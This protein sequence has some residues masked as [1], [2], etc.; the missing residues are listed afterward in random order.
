MQ[1]HLRYAGTHRQ[2][3]LERLILDKLH[4]QRVRRFAEE[5][6]CPTGGEHPGGIVRVVL[7]GAVDKLRQ[8]NALRDSELRQRVG[9]SFGED[10]VGRAG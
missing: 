4:E 1:P 2:R 10:R 6:L 7:Q 8:R 3:R 9:E 5:A